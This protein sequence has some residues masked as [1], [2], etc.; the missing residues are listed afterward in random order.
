MTDV[1]RLRVRG[2]LLIVGALVVG[3]VVKPVGSADL[4]WMPLIIGLTYL[5][6]SAVGGPTGG[7]WIPGLMVTFWG[8]ADV[9]V[10]SGTWHVDFASAAITGIGVGA[11]LSLGL[12]RLGV[13]VNPAAIAVNLLLIGLLELAEAQLGGALTKGWPWALLLLVGALWELRPA[14]TVPTSS[15]ARTSPGAALPPRAR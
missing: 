15:P 7:L 1:V 5:V 10:L 14:V 11:V 2:L 13:P 9:L 12:A 8:L 4:Y 6:A 3:L